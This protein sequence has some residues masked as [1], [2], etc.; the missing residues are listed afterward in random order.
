MQPVITNQPRKG[1]EIRSVARDA[2]CAI[3]F[4]DGGIRATSPIEEVQYRSGPASLPE[5]DQESV[6]GELVPIPR[7]RSA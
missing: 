1:R 3:E 2:G 4:A 5:P 7:R 6:V